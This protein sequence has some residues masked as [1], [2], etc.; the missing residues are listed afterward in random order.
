MAEGLALDDALRLFDRL[1][2]DAC[3]LI[4]EFKTPTGRLQRINRDQRA[5]SILTLWEFLHGTGGAVLSRDTRAARRDWLRDQG[6]KVLHLH[7]GCSAS[8]QSLLET[9]EGPPSVVD[10]LLAAECLARHFPVVT[11]NVRHFI[12]VRGLRYVMW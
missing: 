12:A 7:R 1:I 9:D 5:T 3:V 11:A 10:S 6:I 4:D 8:F 2:L